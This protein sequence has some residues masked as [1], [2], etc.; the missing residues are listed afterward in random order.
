M[1]KDDALKLLA[2]NGRLVKRPIVTDGARVTVGFDAAEFGA[3][4]ARG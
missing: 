4:W 1:P 3:T 2:S